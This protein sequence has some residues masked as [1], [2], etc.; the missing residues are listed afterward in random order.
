MVRQWVDHAYCHTWPDLGVTE[1]SGHT[2]HQLSGI[3]DQ[4]KKK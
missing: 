4:G 3:T 1:P 2:R